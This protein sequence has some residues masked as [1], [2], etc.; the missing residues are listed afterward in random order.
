MSFQTR[1]HPWLLECFG[2]EIS[3]DR[4][5]RNYRFLEESLELVQALGCDQER[6]HELVDYVFGRPLGDPPQEVGGVMV[7]LAALCLAN[8]LDMHISGEI[9][10]ARISTPENVKKIRQ[11]Q[12]M[13]PRFTK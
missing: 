4:E 11:K 3:G 2:E 1:V 8:E 6:A 13:K 9:E 10:L 7:T 5:E 12:V